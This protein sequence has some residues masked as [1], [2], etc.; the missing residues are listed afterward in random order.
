MQ[1]HIRKHFKRCK[2]V[3]P[4]VLG[5]I[6]GDFPALPD[7]TSIKGVVVLQEC[8]IESCEFHRVTLLMDSVT[9]NAFAAQNFP[10]KGI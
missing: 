10:V 3:G 1:A 7:K 6:G 8:S 5:I 9:G 2:I 4:G